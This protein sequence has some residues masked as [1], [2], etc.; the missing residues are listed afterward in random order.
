MKKPDN[1]TSIK[2]CCVNCAF[3]CKLRYHI[4]SELN[5]EGRSEVKQGNADFLRKESATV[6][7]CYKGQLPTAPKYGP[8]VQGFLKSSVKDLCDK[9]CELYY[10]YAGSEN[11]TLKAI[12]QKQSRDTEIDN[13]IIANRAIKLSR[14]GIIISALAL[15]VSLILGIIG[16][17]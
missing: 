10:P 14:T 1:K 15:A 3:L 4:H 9:Q 11:L 16:L 8:W 13:S 5:N 2:P 12:E 6:L 7:A 17:L